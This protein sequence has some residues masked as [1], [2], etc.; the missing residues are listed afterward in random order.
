MIINKIL[1]N[2]KKKSKIRL[3]KIRILEKFCLFKY[4]FEKSN[5]NN[6][7]S[8]SLINDLNLNDKNSFSKNIIL[9]YL[10][11][12]NF[13]KFILITYSL[14]LYKSAF[15][16]LPNF[17]I[18]KINTK[19]KILNKYFSTFFFFIFIFKCYLSCIQFFIKI[20]IFF[21]AK[22]KINKKNYKLVYLSSVGDGNFFFEKDTNNIFTWF[23]KN[24]F[25][26][27][28]K[29]LIIHSNGK[30][31]N[32]ITY[33]NLLIKY[34]EFPFLNSISFKSIIKINFDMIK[35]LLINL[36]NL[37]NFNKHWFDLIILKEYFISNCF[38]YSEFIPRAFYFNNS[39]YLSRPLWSYL[40]K[41]L[42]TY[43]YFYSTN[44]KNLKP[45]MPYFT[46]GFK[47]ANWPFYYLWSISH[48]KEL[49]LKKTNSF[50]YKIISSPIS[51]SDNSHF[52]NKPNTKTISLFNVQPLAKEY[53][54]DYSLDH[55]DYYF[56]ENNLISFYK[57]LIS[58]I[59]NLG[60]K[61]FIKEKRLNNRVSNDYINYINHIKKLSF[62]EYVPEECSTLKVIKSSNLVISIP[63]SSP[64]IIAKSLNVKSIYFDPTNKLIANNMPR[65]VLKF[66]IKII[67]IKLL[68]K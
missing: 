62:I 16:P 50:K 44:Y 22:S 20:N 30:Y 5:L 18:N 56:N 60:I 65:T 41:N 37:F 58:F 13:N 26:N 46:Y 55:H 43:F 31:K 64:S 45:S 63:Y 32:D 34:S 38:K 49:Q 12:N 10:L 51:F 1:Y 23:K 11:A 53:L 17:L 35:L 47:N 52:I 28:G 15:A 4:N 36:F 27:K 6:S 66:L 3:K 54:I 29:Y 61:C 19:I 42:S 48:L 39:D 57:I 33:E 59:E 25:D 2:L 9:N 14:F 24:I 68:R 8:S 7:V 40:H 67:S 21:I